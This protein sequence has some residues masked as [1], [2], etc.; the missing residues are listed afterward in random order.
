MKLSKTFLLVVLL[1][2]VSVAIFVGV[3]A[4]KKPVLKS[5]S[6]QR[7]TETVT[8]S[9]HTAAPSVSDVASNRSITSAQMNAQAKEWQRRMGL[10]QLATNASK[11]EAVKW[12]LSHGGK[13]VEDMGKPIRF[14]GNVVDEHDIPVQGVRAS[15][16]WTEGSPAKTGQK[17]TFSDVSGNFELE[18][19]TDWYLHLSLE[20]EG[21]YVSRRDRQFDFQFSSET[22]QCDPNNPI[23]FHLHKKG[24]GTHLITSQYGVFNDLEFSAPRDGSPTKVD[25][26]NRKVGSDGQL[27]IRQF[28]PAYEN[29]KTA[30]QWSYRLAI[31]DGG[32]VEQ[33]DEFPFEAPLTGY[34]PTVEFNFKQGQTN[35]TTDLIKDYYIA[36]G[37]PRRYG[38]IHIDTSISSRTIL[39]YAI[40]PDGSRYLEPK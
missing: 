9:A 4:V 11:E 13:R 12:L 1:I 35:W 6:P 36:F 16:D 26:F 32:F 30:T 33:N 29:W 39:N 34:Q 23:V 19:V 24:P 2:V 14:Y 15:F 27:E 28:K 17:D 20:K 40:N 18:G 5:G 10:P 7:E 8:K 25:F 3:L 37:N 21:Y 22:G 31:P 38:R